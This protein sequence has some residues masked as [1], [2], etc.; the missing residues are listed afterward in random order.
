MEAKQEIYEQVQS[1]ASKAVTLKKAVTLNIE[2]FTH[3]CQIIGTTPNDLIAKHDSLK[4]PE[5]TIAFVDEMIEKYQKNAPFN[6]AYAYL[7]QSEKIALDP[8]K[9]VQQILN[10]E[11]NICYQSHVV[12]AFA[13]ST[14]GY[15]IRH[16]QAYV[17]TIVSL[18]PEQTRNHKKDGQATHSMLVW[19]Y[20]DGND[21]KER[22]IDV[23]WLNGFH[24]TLEI[25]ADKSS[26]TEISCTDGLKRRCI[27][28]KTD[29]AVEAWSNEKNAWVEE[30]SFNDSITNIDQFNKDLA[31]V[32][33]KHMLSK[34]FIF[35][36]KGV[37]SSTSLLFA[38][39]FKLLT[40]KDPSG[41]SESTPVTKDIAIVLFKKQNV[42]ETISTAILEKT[43]PAPY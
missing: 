7:N 2:F 5:Q 43:F 33:N 40:T 25:A 4:T 30:Y 36:V 41:K 16:T 19:T 37:N 28:V 9:A 22:L 3:F 8:L 17:S 39:L 24:Q 11:S 32:C 34:V 42:P 18:K 26:A 21:T 15:Q 35:L 13:L 38:P 1:N 6:S 23:A 27:K 20:A 12:I 14:L 10:R 29:Y 31:F